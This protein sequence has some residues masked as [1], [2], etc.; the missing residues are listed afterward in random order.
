MNAF[1]GVL[2]TRERK[3]HPECR[4]IVIEHPVDAIVGVPFDP[5]KDIAQECLVRL[6]HLLAFSSLSEE[7]ISL[8]THTVKNDPTPERGY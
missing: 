6:T 1:A 8:I 3:Y 4:A 5:R 7:S 2:F